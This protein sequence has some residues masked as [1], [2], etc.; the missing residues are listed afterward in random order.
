MTKREI[1]ANGNECVTYYLFKRDGTESFLQKIINWYYQD[2]QRK[3]AREA[4]K[5]GFHF[6]NIDQKK[7]FDSEIDSLQHLLPGKGLGEIL[8]R[9]QL[10]LDDPDYPYG[11]PGKLI[12]EKNVDRKDSSLCKKILFDYKLSS[13]DR[14]VK[15]YMEKGTISESVAVGNVSTEKACRKDNSSN[16]AGEPGDIVVTYSSVVPCSVFPNASLHEKQKSLVNKFSLQSMFESIAP[17]AR[18]NRNGGKPAL[19]KAA[20]TVARFV[21]QAKQRQTSRDTSA[22]PNKALPVAEPSGNYRP[23]RARS[24]KAIEVKHMT[25]LDVQDLHPSVAVLMRNTDDHFAMTKECRAWLQRRGRQIPQGPRSIQNGKVTVIESGDNIAYLAPHA[26]SDP[27]RKNF[28]KHLAGI[29][30]IYKQIID[31][32]V[33]NGRP[34]VLTPLFH[35]DDKTIDQYLSAM[36]RP[37]Y[38]H[39]KANKDLR[40]EIRT[41]CQRTAAALEKYQRQYPTSPL[42]EKG[43]PVPQFRSRLHEAD[44]ALE[45]MIMMTPEI[46]DLAG[47]RSRKILSEAGARFSADPNMER[48]QPRKRLAQDAFSKCYFFSDNVSEGPDQEKTRASRQGN[49]S[50]LESADAAAIQGITNDIAAS[51]RAAFVAAR[52]ND[53]R[54]LTLPSLEKRFGAM[55]SEE[56]AAVQLLGIL[57]KLKAEFPDVCVTVLSKNP[58]IRAN[59]ALL[60]SAG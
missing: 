9:R 40:L 58:H 59:F 28:R 26:E 44:L 45:G 50:K 54:F 13:P 46:L 56:L 53:C 31:D 23:S 25:D 8:C 20:G 4:I 35:Y 49:A 38:A 1:D 5:A 36:L 3:N 15:S 39:L 47:K 7:D 11:T 55:L 19:S 48:V 60:A 10:K 12:E 41:T 29:A 51:Y 27:N 22:V 33:A 30:S 37:V 18:S 24:I 14:S 17:F 52:E 21:G 6:L 57:R 42:T 2:E 34:I 43:K 16:H 32:A